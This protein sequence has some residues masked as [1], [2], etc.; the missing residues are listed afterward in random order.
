MSAVNPAN[1]IFRV[2]GDL[3][4][5]SPSFYNSSNALISFRGDFGTKLGQIRAFGFQGGITLLLDSAECIGGLCVRS[6]TSQGDP[7]YL[8]NAKNDQYALQTT[9]TGETTLKRLYVEL[10]S[11]QF[12]SSFDGTS[13]F[14]VIKPNTSL[15]SSLINSLAEL[16]INSMRA[17]EHV[18]VLMGNS[19]FNGCCVWGYQMGNT[20]SPSSN[21]NTSY[22]AMRSSGNVTTTNIRMYTNGDVDIPTKLKVGTIEA[23]NYLGLSLSPL[24]LDAANGYVGINNSTPTDGLSVLGTVLLSGDTNIEGFLHVK[25]GPIDISSLG[26]IVPTYSINS[27]PVL[28]ATSLGSGV[29]TSSLTS[30][31]TLGLLNVTNNINIGGEYQV[32]GARALRMTAAGSIAMGPQSASLG[33]AQGSGAIAIGNLAGRTTQGAGS[34]AVGPNSGTTSQG[35]SCVAVGLGTGNSTQGNYAVAVGEYA[36]Q[37]GQLT[38]GISIGSRAGQNTQQA[39]AIAIGNSAGNTTQGAQGIAIGRVAGHTDQKLNAVAIGYNAGNLTQG[40]HAVA[41]GFEAGKTTQGNNAVAIGRNAGT[42]NQHTNSIV[43]NSSGVELNSTVAD[44][45]YVKPIRSDETKT[46]VLGYDTTSGEIV[47]MTKTS[48]PTPTIVTS[49]L[50]ADL[51]AVTNTTENSVTP[52]GYNNLGSVSLTSGTWS[53][54]GFVYLVIPNIST[55]GVCISTSTTWTHDPENNCFFKQVISGSITQYYT[56][57]VNMTVTIS[58]TTTFYLLSSVV[59]NPS[60]PGSYT[61]GKNGL[62]ATK[63][64]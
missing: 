19:T 36:G 64:A 24:T 34:V 7:F 54:D 13:I 61:L 32:G 44:S 18:Q 21:L 55:V 1:Q 45:F 10:K 50:S 23:T 5:Q 27:I 57:K 62:R 15:A 26:P 22:F 41:I 42:T 47:Y 17:N 37:N 8:E 12:A 53:I 28:T 14:K 35:L 46:K 9:T 33:T 20:T 11:T 43:I 48:T 58:A 39:Y 29:L 56:D 2:T 38:Y 49:W 63:I 60:H 25:D 31:G 52:T 16:Y 6:N 40:Q 3:Q 30:V 59:L 4:V 51:P